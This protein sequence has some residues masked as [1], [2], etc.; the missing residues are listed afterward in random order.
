MLVGERIARRFGRD[1][2]EVIL[3]LCGHN[4]PARLLEGLATGHLTQLSSRD[5]LLQ[6]RAENPGHQKGTERLYVEATSKSPVLADLQTNRP[7]CFLGPLCDLLGC[8]GW[9]ARLQRIVL[10]EFAP[11]HLNGSI[12]HGP[13]A[14]MQLFPLFVLW[15]CSCNQ[16]C[17]V[18]SWPWED[19][20]QVFAMH[21]KISST[22][23]MYCW[24]YRRCNLHT[25]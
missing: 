15:N 2:D 12:G 17:S 23:F 18:S 19:S 5:P 8:S 6:L 22:R 3:A 1:L 20:L 25:H 24:R 11:F 7:V 4:P 13:L 9:S 16:S 21:T 14:Y 10:C